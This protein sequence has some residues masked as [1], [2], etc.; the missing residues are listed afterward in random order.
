MNSTRVSVVSVI[1][2]MR[3][4]RVVNSDMTII[5]A[6]LFEVIMEH[7]FFSYNIK[8]RERKLICSQCIVNNQLHVYLSCKTNALLTNLDDDIQQVSLLAEE[9]VGC[10]NEKAPYID[11]V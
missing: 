1:R 9:H 7:L 2:D 6:N 10:T 4:V 8:I 11:V 5:Q 3:N